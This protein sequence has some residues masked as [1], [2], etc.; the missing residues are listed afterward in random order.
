MS[1]NYDQDVKE[2]FGKLSVNHSSS[3]IG[4][5]VTLSRQRMIKNPKLPARIAG[6]PEN[7]YNGLSPVRIPTD[8]NQINFNGQLKFEAE[9]LALSF[10]ISSYWPENEY[11]I[12]QKI[13][14]YMPGVVRLKPGDRQKNLSHYPRQY[15]GHFIWSW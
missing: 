2:R 14:T 9:G 13:E 15:P 5:E 3:L 8:K 12:Q 1:E 7:T 6:N 10:K 11:V 4:W